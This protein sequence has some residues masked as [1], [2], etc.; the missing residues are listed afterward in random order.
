MVSLNVKIMEYVF[1]R[2]NVSGLTLAFAR[3]TPDAPLPPLPYKNCVDLDTPI[4]YPR[5]PESQASKMSSRTHRVPSVRVETLD[6]DSTLDFRPTIRSQRNFHLPRRVYTSHRSPSYMRIIRL[7][8]QVLSLISI[9]RF[10]LRYATYPADTALVSLRLG[11]LPMYFDAVEELIG[12]IEHGMDCSQAYSAGGLVRLA[13]KRYFRHVRRQYGA[14][15]AEKEWHWPRVLWF[16]ELQ[17]ILEDERLSVG[18]ALKSGWKWFMDCDGFPAKYGGAREWVV[19][20]YKLETEK[21][22]EFSD[23]FDVTGE[24]LVSMAR[25]FEGISL[26]DPEVLIHEKGACAQVFVSQKRILDVLMP[27]ML[28]PSTQKLGRCSLCNEALLKEDVGTSKE[29]RPVEIICRHVFH[30]SCIRKY[31]TAPDTWICPGCN[32][33]LPA[34]TTQPTTPTEV[35]GSC[36]KILR[37]L[38]APA[39]IT[40]PAEP[41]S[42]LAKLALIFEPAQKICENLHNWFNIPTDSYTEL[43][44]LSNLVLYLARDRLEAAIQGDVSKFRDVVAR[45]LQ[46]GAR[47]E[48]LEFLERCHPNSP[49]VW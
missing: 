18:E 23:I 9:L 44:G 12:H 49:S 28:N 1:F 20:W 15:E 7:E 32:R 8:G 30:F 35:L 47:I 10:H 46:V 42:Y 11:P 22:A 31:F 29:T 5:E 13:Q 3:S 41:H 21:Q 38:D 14:K 39:Q 16:A 19:G 17:S 37:W 34:A 36:D 27:L 25:K 45:Q 6:S 43:L 26:C 40:L 24:S 4:H 33:N 2:F 48:W